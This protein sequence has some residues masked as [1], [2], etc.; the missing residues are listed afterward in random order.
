MLQRQLGGA[1]GRQAGLN[2]YGIGPVFF[3][4]GESG[5]ELLTVADAYRADR[6]SGGFA[7][8]LDLLEERFGEGIGRVRQGGHAARRWQHVAAQLDT[9]ASQ[10][11]GNESHARHISAWPRKACD[12]PRT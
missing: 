8:K 6:S 1:F 4:R 3:H 12:Q 10:F 2:D 7:A 5:L 9:L 11:G